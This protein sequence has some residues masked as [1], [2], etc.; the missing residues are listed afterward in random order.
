MMYCLIFAEYIGWI[1]IWC[2]FIAWRYAR[3]IYAVVMCPSVRPMGMA[4]HSSQITFGRTCY[5]LF[6]YWPVGLLAVHRSVHSAILRSST[7]LTRR[8]WSLEPWGRSL[9]LSNVTVRAQMPASTTTVQHHR[10]VTEAR[11]GL[12]V[13]RQPSNS[14]HHQ[15]AFF[16]IH[17]SVFSCI[18]HY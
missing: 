5:H 11:A 1:Q 2:I 6:T 18:A 15:Y 9:P 16:A 17:F 12:P 10:P 14:Y 4:M 7:V 3:A 13:Q 8:R